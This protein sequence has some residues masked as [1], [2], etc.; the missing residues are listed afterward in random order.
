M[1]LVRGI[2]EGAPLNERNDMETKI[3]AKFF[4]YDGCHKMYIIESDDDLKS[5]TSYGYQILPIEELPRTYVESC[6]LRFID[7]WDLINTY[8]PQ[9]ARVEFIGWDLDDDV[10]DAIKYLN[11]G[12]DEDYVDGIY[13]IVKA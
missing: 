10:R 6:P 13:R 11:S 5:A 2:R 4:A 1:V 3:N 12:D 9:C 8:V 7:P